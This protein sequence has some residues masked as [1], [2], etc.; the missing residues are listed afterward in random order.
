M[1]Q[2]RELGGLSGVAQSRGPRGWR[3]PLECG[4]ERK[5]RFPV[6]GAVKALR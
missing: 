4:L 2:A 6:C 3:R 5:V 1:C